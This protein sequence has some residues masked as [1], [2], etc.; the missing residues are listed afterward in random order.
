MTA[1]VFPSP[2]REET[3]GLCELAE[4][5]GRLAQRLYES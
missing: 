1:T 3:S 2:L 4:V 5:R